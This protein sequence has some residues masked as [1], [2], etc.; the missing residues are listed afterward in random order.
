MI[1]VALAA[2]PFAPSRALAAAVGGSWESD[3]GGL[4]WT[5]SDDYPSVL[6][7]SLVFDVEFAGVAYAGAAQGVWKSIDG[8]RTWSAAASG[9]PAA[10]ILALLPVPGSG[11]AVVAATSQ[12][13]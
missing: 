8:G 2:D 7:A 11:G 5:S 13:V 3:D 6:P 4:S 12:G 9:L 1:I 10:V